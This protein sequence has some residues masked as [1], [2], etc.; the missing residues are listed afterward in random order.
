M[1]TRGRRRR[2][3]N[4]RFREDVDWRSGKIRVA[5]RLTGHEADL[6][7]EAVESL[8]RSGHLRITVDLQKVRGADDDGLAVLRSL[9]AGM[10]KRSA[11]LVVLSVENLSEEETE[12]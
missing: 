1:S 9:A 4:P 12:P 8:R 5:G 2:C 10:Q 3:W 7:G 11:Q 6:I